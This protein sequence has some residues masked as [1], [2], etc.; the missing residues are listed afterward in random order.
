LVVVPQAGVGDKFVEHELRAEQFTHLRH[1][2]SLHAHQHRG[3][4]EQACEDHLERE[5]WSKLREQMID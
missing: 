4:R 3:W 5:I 1:V 2:I